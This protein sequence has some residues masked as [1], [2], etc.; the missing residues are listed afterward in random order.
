MDIAPSFLGKVKKGV[1]LLLNLKEKSWSKYWALPTSIITTTI[2]SHLV[3][4]RGIRKMKCWPEIS[5]FWVWWWWVGWLT[6]GEQTSK[7]SAAADADADESNVVLIYYY[8]S[9]WCIWCTWCTRQHNYQ[10]QDI[11]YSLSVRWSTFRCAWTGACLCE[12]G[13]RERGS[14]WRCCWR[15]RWWWL[16]W[17]QCAC[18]WWWRLKRSRAGQTTL[19]WSP[20]HWWWWMICWRLMMVV[21]V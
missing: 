16:W 20:K 3:Q 6:S 10:Y 4:A 11:L 9:C 5:R 19:R 17:W 1:F 12:G 15:W 18:F 13:N 7:W 8:Y 2:Q 21:M 14:W